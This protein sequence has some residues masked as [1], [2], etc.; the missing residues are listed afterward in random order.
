M[1][2]YSKVTEQDLIKLRKLAE[3]QKEQRALKIKNRILKETHGV[4]L[5]ESLSPITEK[6]DEVK[7]STRKV[8]DIIKESNSKIDLKSMK[9]SSKYSNSMRQ[10][11]GSLMNIRNSL[12]IIQDESNR[13]TIL[14]VPIQISEDDKIKINE[15]VYE[16]S[17]EIFKALSDPLYKGKT[18]KNDEEFLMLYSI[19]KDINYTGRRDRPSN[20]KT[21]FTIELPEKVSE[22][23]YMR[24]HENTDDSDD[25]QGEGV[26]NINPFKHYCYLH[27]T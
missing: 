1:S 2:I 10:M 15:N 16:L 19:L 6:L 18:M 17:P 25:L 11:I 12:K 5:A 9:N 27:K 24:F 7:K 20:R 14:N 22:I 23:H 3:E 4:K 26:K 21:F 13:A 8:G